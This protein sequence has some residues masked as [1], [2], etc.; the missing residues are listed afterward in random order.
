MIIKYMYN[1]HI[2]IYNNNNDNNNNQG[3]ILHFRLQIIAEMGKKN[4]HLF[5][6]SV[7]VFLVPAPGNMN[8]AII[9]CTCH[10]G[11]M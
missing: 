6:V 8:S 3:Q 11:G 2:Y 1:N 5:V 9:Y 10:S 4:T 7:T